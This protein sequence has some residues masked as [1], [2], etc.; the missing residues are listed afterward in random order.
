MD[1]FCRLVTQQVSQRLGQ[2]L[3]V[4]NKPGV[5]GHL[6]LTAV[7]RS[8]PD[9]YT[10]SCVPHSMTQSP[11]MSPITI[12]VLKDLAPIARLARWQFMLVVRG[13]HP[14]KTLP[15]FIALAK[16]KPGTISVGSAGASTR[17]ATALLEE[18]AGIQTLP[19]PFPGTAAVQVAILGGHVDAAVG[20][21]TFATLRGVGDAQPRV[22]PLAVMAAKRDPNVPNVPAISEFFPGLDLAAWYG[23]VAPAGT[24]AQIIKRLNAEFTAVV[25]A[26]PF[27]EQLAGRGW[28][29]DTNSPEEFAAQISADYERYGKAIQQLKLKK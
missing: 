29:A 8:A 6:G 4:L 11:H 23:I 16:E 9:G 3:V 18:R 5:E 13:E 20:D 12:D 2:P 21:A 26:S 7:A 28:H 10:I 24:P 14:A 22:R 25:N 19:V 15:D 1:T 17:L 27:K